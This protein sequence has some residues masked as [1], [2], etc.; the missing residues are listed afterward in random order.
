MRYRSFSKS[1]I[2]VSEVG[3]GAWGI[4]KSMWIGADD[5]ESLRSLRAARDA[6]V[7][8]FD[9]ALVYG[10]G[11]SEQLI[12]RA[13]GKSSDVIIAS[14][15]PPADRVWAVKSGSPLRNTF[16]KEYVLSCLDQSLKHL[17]REHIDIYQ[18]HTWHDDWARQSEWQETVRELKSS[19]KVRLVGISIQNHQ[20]ANVLEALDTGL[21]DSVQVIYNIF[22]Q[23]PE[24]QLFPYCKQH[25]VGVIVRVPFDEGALAGKIAPETTFPEGDFRHAYFA[26]NRK[27]EVADAVQAIVR[28]TGISRDEL[29]SLALRFCLSPS[30]VSTVIPGMR[31]VRHVAANV[32]A[33]DAGPLPPETLQKLRAHRWVRNFWL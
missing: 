19:G 15:V 32:A 3:Y 11:H 14:K 9:T 28:D 2:E 26:G 31:D 7:N 12:A 6:G 17:G 8:F 25:S 10:D 5:A 1:G 16:P 30:A 27:Q 18:F 21:V 24:D 22:D 23:S 13:F 20:P 4:G 33:S 29:P